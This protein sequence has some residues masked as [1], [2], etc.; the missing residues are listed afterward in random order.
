VRAHQAHHSF[1][2][3]GDFSVVPSQYAPFLSAIISTDT[4]YFDNHRGNLVYTMALPV[5]RLHMLT[6]RPHLSPTIKDGL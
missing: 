4:I 2:R 5:V 1:Q 6:C 3:K